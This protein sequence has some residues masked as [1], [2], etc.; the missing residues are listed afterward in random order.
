[1]T[2][3]EVNFGLSLLTLFKNFMDHKLDLNMWG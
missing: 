2:G 3:G 1:M